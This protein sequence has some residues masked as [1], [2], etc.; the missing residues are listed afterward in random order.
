MGP[1]VQGSEGG[2]NSTCVDRCKGH[3]GGQQPTVSWHLLL[4]VGGMEGEG[5]FFLCDY[6]VTSYKTKLQQH[7]FLLS[8][9]AVLLKQPIVTVKY[10]LTVFGRHVDSEKQRLRLRGNCG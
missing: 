1:T 3:A 2:G 7:T 5:V 6:I 10:I 8:E 4:E 9:Y